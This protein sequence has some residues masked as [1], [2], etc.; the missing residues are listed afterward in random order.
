MKV[1]RVAECNFIISFDPG[2]IST[3]QAIAAVLA[4]GGIVDLTI[5]EP[6]LE[7]IIAEAFTLETFAEGQCAR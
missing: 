6:P 5:G 2:Q 4:Q 7:E 3:D 1:K